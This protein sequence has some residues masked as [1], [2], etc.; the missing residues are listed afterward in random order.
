MTKGRPVEDTRQKINDAATEHGAEE[1]SAEAFRETV[2][3]V[4][5][6][7]KTA[8]RIIASKRNRRPWPR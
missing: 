7:I 4:A 6:R 3:D 8:K 2:R 1:S 5:A